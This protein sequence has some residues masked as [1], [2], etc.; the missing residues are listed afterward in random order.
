MGHAAALI[1][2]ANRGAS[3]YSGAG[4]KSASDMG[5]HNSATA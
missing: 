5:K 3:T 1:V 4:V 2:A